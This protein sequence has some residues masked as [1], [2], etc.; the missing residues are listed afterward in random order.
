MQYDDFQRAVSVCCRTRFLSSHAHFR[1]QDARMRCD[2][3]QRAVSVCGLDIES[4]KDRARQQEDACTALRGQ[5]D[6]RMSP[7]FNASAHT[8]L[9]FSHIN[10]ISFLRCTFVA[11]ERVREGGYLYHSRKA[12]RHEDVPLSQCILS[13]VSHVCLA[14]FSS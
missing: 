3:L 2:E 11:E 7:L 10:S 14:D 6:V 4:L 13:A 5:L 8:C 9:L 12:I 1:V